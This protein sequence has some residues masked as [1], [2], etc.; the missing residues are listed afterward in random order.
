MKRLKAK[1]STVIIYAPTL[2]DGT[3]FFG[4]LI[5]NDIKNLREEQILLSLQT[6]MILRWMMF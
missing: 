5:V 6:D 1:G 4:S 2:T 3:T